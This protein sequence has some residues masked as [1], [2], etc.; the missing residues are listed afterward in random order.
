M[1][2]KFEIT[3]DILTLTAD[4]SEYVGRIGE[5]TKS[6]LSKNPMLRKT[7]RIR[8]IQG[9]L[10]I[11]QNTLSIEEV[12]AV[13]NGKTVL[14]PPKDIAEVKNAYEIYESL[15]K[16]RVASQADLC[17]AHGIMM[18]GLVPDA[19]EY[20][21]I[22]VGVVNQN[23]EVIHLGT[24][25]R[26][27][28]ESMDGLFEWLR[29]SKLHPLIKSCVFHYEFEQIHPFADGNGRMGR[30]WHTLILSKW[31]PLFAWLP[32]ES[33]IY[34]NQPDYYKVLNACENADNSTEF[35]FF[36]LT[37]IK[38]TICEA[39]EQV[40]E[41]DKKQVGAQVEEQVNKILEFCKEPKSRDEIQA[42]CKI[43]GRKQF[44]SRYL[45]PLLES[46][47]L[48]MTIPE[49]PNSRLQKYVAK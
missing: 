36:M 47:K 38:K 19:G 21:S 30:L 31:N 46:G 2:P 18:R 11:E 41:Q 37:V 22:P 10:A 49:K 1:K 44:T 3:E 26:Y 28:P 33:M 32:V 48:V 25:P 6:K 27:V 43:D 23:N 34:K 15:D 24:L 4:I 42:F 16:L 7:N 17:T 14:A 13:L 8:T 20:R 35:I 45:K 39:M 12:T 5:Y 9:T 40:E 29:A